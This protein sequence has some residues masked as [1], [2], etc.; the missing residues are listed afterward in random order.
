MA[1]HAAPIDRETRPIR[2]VRGCEMR[3]PPNISRVCA[4]AWCRAGTRIQCWV[5]RPWCPT[6][7]GGSMLHEV[8]LRPLLSQQGRLRGWVVTDGVNEVRAEADERDEALAVWRTS[9]RTFTGAGADVDACMYDRKN[10]LVKRVTARA[11][12]EWIEHPPPT[13]PTA[14]PA[15]GASS[16][17]SRPALSA[18]ATRAPTSPVEARATTGKG[19]KAPRSRRSGLRCRPRARAGGRAPGRPA[20]AGCPARCGSPPP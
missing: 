1:C 7:T 16:T 13:A 20:P 2:G 5:S 14:P 9:I 11:T 15:P 4:Q 19:G 18:P 6:A 10:V 3:S 17:A 8:V 12:G